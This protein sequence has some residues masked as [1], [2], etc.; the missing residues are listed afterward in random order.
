MARFRFGRHLLSGPLPNLGLADLP[1]LLVRPAADVIVDEQPNKREAVVE[2]GVYFLRAKS[3][4]Q[5]CD[6]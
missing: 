5:Q 1:R 4:D 2:A 6:P 3:M